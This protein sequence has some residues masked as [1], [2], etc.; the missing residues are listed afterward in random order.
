VFE[1]L[2]VDQ[3]LRRALAVNPSESVLADAADGLATLRASA[4]RRAL[5]GETTF[6]EVAR[7]SPGP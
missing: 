4:V 2:P 5:R 6:D 1:V 7:V 3:R